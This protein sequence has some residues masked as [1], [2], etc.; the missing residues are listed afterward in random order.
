MSTE[1]GGS[2]TSWIGHVKR[3][4]QAS[5]LR[6]WERYYA[7]L[8][9]LARVR[10]ASRPRCSAEQD[11]EDAVLGAFDN[12]YE[13]AARG[14][15][16]RV[17]NRDDLWRLL[18]VITARKVSDQFQRQ[19]RKKRGGGAG[20]ARASASATRGEEGP[21]D[22]MLDR[23]IGREPSPEFAAM[24]ADEIRMGLEALGEESLRRVAVLR[25]EGYSSAE[26]AGELGCARRTVDYKLEYIRNFWVAKAEEL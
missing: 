21:A 14:Q 7:R 17:R 11:E 8:V 6:L 26:I 12:F 22:D 25:L 1:D 18:V 13:G 16:P 3:G 19:G 2:V 10:L 23:I 4:D 9:A 20:L 5:A 15:Y 24:V